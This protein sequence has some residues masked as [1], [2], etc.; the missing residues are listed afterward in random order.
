[1][2]AKVP[3]SNPSVKNPFREL[4]YPW[5]PST[6]IVVLEDLSLMDNKDPPD[7][8]S[9]EKFFSGKE[10]STLPVTDRILS[11]K[12]N[13]PLIMETHRFPSF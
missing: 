8:C 7:L 12:S 13:N 4:R 5:I 10:P 6:T 11:L 1:L 9:R 3:G 2:T